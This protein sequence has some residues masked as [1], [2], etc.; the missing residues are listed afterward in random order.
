MPK[1]FEFGDVIMA[2]EAFHELFA[3]GHTHLC[4]WME[5]ENMLSEYLEEVGESAYDDCYDDSFKIMFKE[6]LLKNKC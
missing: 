4:G 1:Q 2:D 3:E 5:C 6:W